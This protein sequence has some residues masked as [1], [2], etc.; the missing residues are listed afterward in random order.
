MGD[1]GAQLL[2]CQVGRVNRASSMGARRLV[3][4]AINPLAMPSQVRILPP[5]PVRF[6]RKADVISITAHCC[7]A[8]QTADRRHGVPKN[9]SRR[10]FPKGGSLSTIGQRPLLFTPLDMDRPSCR[11]P[12]YRRFLP[13]SLGSPNILLGRPPI[14]SA[15]RGPRVIASINKRRRTQARCSRRGLL[16]DI[17]KFCDS[18]HTMN[19]KSCDRDHSMTVGGK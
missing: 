11:E 1:G 5:A 16:C 7:E 19:G 4:S 3:M 18:D 12:N 10:R 8:G 2:C 13:A 15:N 17:R 14:I 6:T 9:P